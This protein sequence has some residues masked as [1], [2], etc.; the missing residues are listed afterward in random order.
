MYDARIPQEKRFWIVNPIC[1]VSPHHAMSV[2]K[3]VISNRPRIMTAI[4]WAT[5]R[6]SVRKVLGDC[7]LLIFKDDRVQYPK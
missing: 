4:D 1:Q 2:E 3:Q 6:P 5:E 7:Q